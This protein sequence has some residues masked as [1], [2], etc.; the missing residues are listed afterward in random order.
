MK[1]YFLIKKELIQ[2]SIKLIL[3]VTSFSL[4]MGCESL[5]KKQNTVV[6]TSA[7]KNGSTL[8]T[9]WELKSLVKNTVTGEASIIT[10]DLVGAKTFPIRAE[11]STS[12][13]LHMAS[14]VIQENEIQYILPRSK[15]YFSGPISQKSLQPVLNVKLDPRLIQAALF[16]LSYPDWKCSADNGLI[17]SCESAVNEKISWDRSEGKAKLVNIKGDDYEVQIQFVNESVKNDVKENTFTLKVPESYKK[18]KL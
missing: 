17:S 15:R 16:D 11:I 5:Q 18:F 4:F 1:H 9:Q 3:F 6:P 13:G 14:V 7:S 10:L 8:Y 2:L 12:V